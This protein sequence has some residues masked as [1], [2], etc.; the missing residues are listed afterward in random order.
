MRAIFKVLV[1][2]LGTIVPLHCGAQIGP[3]LEL[4]GFT[5]IK[6]DTKH[7][8]DT[9]SNDSISEIS[10]SVRNIGDEPLIISQVHGSDPC[11]AFSKPYLPINPGE[12]GFII[13]RCPTRPNFRVST[14]F[15][16]Y[17]NGNLKSDTRFGVTQW[18]KGE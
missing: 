6:N 15:M 10:I 2:V 9:V 13:I 12:R 16:I 4:E 17:S 18:F 5:L 8:I 7:F 11:Y 3:Q 1:V 14:S